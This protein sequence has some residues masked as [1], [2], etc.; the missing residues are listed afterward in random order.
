MARSLLTVEEGVQLTFT[1]DATK[2][3]FG[4]SGREL[5]FFNTNTVTPK[6]KCRHQS[7][8]TRGL[9]FP[10]IKREKQIHFLIITIHNIPG[11]T[12]Q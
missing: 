3:S 11:K 9:T 10:Q 6:S 8:S 5:G 7:L 4:P 2:H 12:R 1:T